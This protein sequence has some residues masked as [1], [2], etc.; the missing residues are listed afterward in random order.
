MIRVETVPRITSTQTVVRPNVGDHC[1]LQCNASYEMNVRWMKG[2]R[3]VQNKDGYLAEK[4]NNGLVRL[5]HIF[6]V[7]PEDDG[8]YACE[9]RAFGFVSQA[10]IH[11]EVLIPAEITTSPKNQTVIVSKQVTFNCK[12]SGY[13]RPN[14]SWFKYSQQ[15][16]EE[17]LKEG[18]NFIIAMANK[19]HAGIYICRASNRIGKPAK[20]EV[21][22]NVTDP[23][24]MTVRYRQGELAI[25]KCDVQKETQGVI[26]NW[27]KAGRDLRH[28]NDSHYKVSMP[29]L[30]KRDFSTYLIINSVDHK[31]EGIY[32]CTVRNYLKIIIQVEITDL[33]VLSYP[34]PPSDLKLNFSCESEWLVATWSPSLTIGR[35]RPVK[36]YSSRITL[37]SLLLEDVSFTA[38]VSVKETFLKVTI[39]GFCD[40]S[41]T[42][43]AVDVQA[44]NDH[45]LSPFVRRVGIISKDCPSFPSQKLSSDLSVIFIVQMRKVDCLCRQNLK[46]KREVKRKKQIYLKM[47]QKLFPVPGELGLQ[48]RDSNEGTANDDISAHHLEVLLEGKSR[49]STYQLVKLLAVQREEQKEFRVKI[50]KCRYAVNAKCVKTGIKDY[51]IPCIN[52]CDCYSHTIC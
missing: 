13:P 2:G 1:V 36:T 52:E 12:A 32:T 40:L 7:T 21:H 28:L 18:N 33:V 14:I 38:N 3:N 47:T 22:L 10:H 9:G 41:C 30:Q 16:G 43:Y 35:N 24:V 42:V 11:V 8:L 44:V 20:A 46:K 49:L 31:D 27:T 4:Q 15:F 34:F 26:V 37:Y 51:S 25:L 23:E 29:A 6:K 39:P 5:L 17:P 19:G 45:G 50:G 48:V